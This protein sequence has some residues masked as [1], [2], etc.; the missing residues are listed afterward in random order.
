MAEEYKTKTAISFYGLSD[1]IARQF[2]IHILNVYAAWDAAGSAAGSAAKDAAWNAAWNA[3]GSAAGHAAWAAARAA[4]WDATWGAAMDAAGGAAM[5]AAW[6]AAWDAA[7]DVAK[8]GGTAR[9]I[10]YVS[11][12]SVI[13]DRKKIF[14]SIDT[15]GDK[16]PST[17]MTVDDVIRVCTVMMTFGEKEFTR[18]QSTI[19]LKMLDYLLG[20]ERAISFLHYFPIGNR[21]G[22]STNQY[23]CSYRELMDKHRQLVCDLGLE[24][25]YA[26]LT[27]PRHEVSM[28]TKYLPMMPIVLIEI[29]IE[30][31]SLCHDASPDNTGDS[32]EIYNRLLVLEEFQIL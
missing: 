12:R 32:D 26:K 30:Y 23:H 20:Y 5:G 11:C 2:R 13:V 25:S 6:T 27:A 16:I 21:N 3:A 17:P 22:G 8:N 14:S 9:Q 28:L 10:A 29:M 7:K 18:L 15:L 19:P 31:S 24:K 4:T 1:D